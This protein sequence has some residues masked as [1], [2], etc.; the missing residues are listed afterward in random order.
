MHATCQLR[1]VLPPPVSRAQSQ[2]GALFPYIR[3][4]LIDPAMPTGVRHLLNKLTAVRKG[5]DHFTR[6]A[7][8][9]RHNVSPPMRQH[10]LAI[11][12]AVC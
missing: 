12:I 4:S 11:T 6:G 10:R 2:P 1:I 3:R 7:A 5:F 9:R 8:A